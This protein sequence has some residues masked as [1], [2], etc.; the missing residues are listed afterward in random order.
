MAGISIDGLISGLNT[1]SII[2][3]LVAI[4]T[5]RISTLE[6]RQAA[7]TNNIS[8]FQSLQG[9][10][11]G[12]LSSANVLTKQSFFQQ[13]TTSSSDT[14][15]LTVTADDDAPLGSTQLTVQQLATKNQFVSNRFADTNITTFGLG[16]LSIT[17]G[18]GAG[19]VTKQVTIDSTN[20]TVEGI[21][22]LINNSGASVKAD[23]LKVDD[24][25]APFQV[26][27]TANEGGTANAVSLSFDAAI[28]TSVTGEVL[29]SGAATATQDT[30]DSDTTTFGLR[31][32]PNAGTVT[33]KIDGAAI[34]ASLAAPSTGLGVVSIDDNTGTLTVGREYAYVVSAV[35]ASGET[36]QSST[37]T[38][39]LAVGSESIDFSF[40]DVDGATSYRI[41]RLD[42]TEYAATG[43]GALEATDFQQQDSLIGT[44]TDDGSAS[45]T[46]RDTGQ[47]QQASQRA[48]AAATQ[49]YTLT[50]STGAVVFNQAQTGVVTADYEY[51]FEFKESEQAKD[52]I[53]QLGSGANAV[54]I[55]KSSNTISDVIEGVTLNLKKVDA[56]TP[57][58]IDVKRNDFSVTGSV[59]GFIKAVNE[60]QKFINDNS[61]FNT[62]TNA[63]GAFLGDSNILTIQTRLNDILLSEV[64][65]LP[66]D[67]LRS[68]IGIGVSLAGDT[69][70][71][72]LGQTRL[73]GLLKSKAEEV[74]KVFA[75]VASAA[76]VD[77]KA[78]G[79]TE[80]T[81]IS[82]AS[83]YAVNITRA[84]TR[85]Q[86]EGIQN[87]AGGITVEE[88]L[89][90]DVDGTVTSVKLTSGLTAE[91]AVAAINSA[92]E[93]VN[94]NDARAVFNNAT[95]KISIRHDEYGS[96]HIV[97]ITST[98]ANST[99]G[100]TGLGASTA[101]S[102]TV[103]VGQ[104]VAGTINSEAATGSGQTLT[105]NEGNAR[106]DGLQI[107]VTLTPDS[108]TTQGSPQGT[109]VVSRGVASKMKEFLQFLTDT[110]Q[111]GPIQ[112][113]LQ[114]SDN[115]IS[116]LQSQID[117]V[118]A[119]AERARER[120]IIEFAALEQAL[121]TL[122]TTSTFLDG[123]LAQLATTSAS[124]IAR[125][126]RRR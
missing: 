63:S 74:A 56:S 36:L 3:Q 102:T 82:A 54:T 25:T 39:T 19:A 72:T 27:V 110:S 31:H 121:G 85:A 109:V 52:A 2:D 37:F 35:D 48:L 32:L 119:Q 4:Q 123:Q 125:G 16:T 43:T 9:L 84:A 101:N 40:D 122:Q 20:N 112:A 93:N 105:A 7:E 26:I 103:N 24:S 100:A 62:E 51:D 17:T 21:V 76:D 46:F 64:D 33:I 15:I 106:T 59:D 29:G 38:H 97:K 41:Y 10:A 94:I 120:L 88:T 98:V 90:I 95:G 47:A 83:G 73:S 86:R 91:K 113:A 111:E 108:L 81:K 118:L 49:G 13:R 116:D 78:L 69:G 5:S 8:L 92:L 80:K 79:F 114:E 42:D 70:T 30:D 71:F 65:S 23:I 53:V 44:V 66:A 57:V 50:E 117:S 126:G 67:Q 99:A 61:F 28:K 55:R 12:V 45:F 14:D 1:S 115:R 107:L 11:L 87:V 104:D 22:D 124:I 60:F 77:I 18:T 58:I 89:T 6:A 75:D 96:S 68:L 34:T